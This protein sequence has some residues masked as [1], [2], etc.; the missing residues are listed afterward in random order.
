MFTGFTAGLELFGLADPLARLPGLLNETLQGTR[1]I[2]H[3]DLNLENVLVGPGGFVWLIDFAQTREGHPLFDFSH[4]AAEIVAHII[5]PGV[6][7][8]QAYLQSLTTG[9]QPL[10]SAV[11]AIASRCLFNPSE[12]REYRLS[13]LLACLGA[14]KYPNLGATEKHLLYLTAAWVSSLL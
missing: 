8:P 2:I 5:A 14:L 13:L 7:S 4:L 11:E 1:S 3:G 12:P 6:S 10:L 9:Q